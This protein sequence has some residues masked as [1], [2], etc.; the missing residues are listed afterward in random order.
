MHLSL[1]CHLRQRLCLVAGGNHLAETRVHQLLQ[2]GADI[3]VCASEL[4]P[5]LSALAE[6]QQIR[7]NQGR[8]H[9]GLLKGC[10]L[11]VATTS[12][13]TLNNQISRETNSAQIFCEI[14]QQQGS[15]AVLQ[16]T[17]TVLPPEMNIPSPGAGEV[18][19]VGAGP[20]DAGLLTLKALSCLQQADVVLA[21]RLV[22]DDIR[23]LICPAT[24]YISVGKQCG[25]HSTTQQQINQ[26]L[27]SQAQSGKRVV[28][29]KGGD[30]LIF[31]RGGEELEALAAT[32]I[33]FSV[34]PGITAASGCAAYAGI[35]LTHRDYA[36]SLR[37]IT[38]HTKHAASPPFLSGISPSQTT[39]FYMGL[40]QAGDI[41]QQL[42]AAGVS[43]QTP[44]AVIG[45]GTRREQKVSVG[46][47]HELQ[48]LCKDA[49]SPALII[50]GEVVRLQH[51]LNW[52]SAGQ[53]LI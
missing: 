14:S 1:V 22:S 29:L 41:Y 43:D 8:Y 12:D 25:R 36:D 50:V 27:I 34:V 28:R 4:T 20:G 49:A 16:T 11:V 32:G 38:G 37:L 33:R 42:T 10:W 23:A 6:Q 24:E 45:K 7:W 18:A 44:V 53:N 19:L 47:L 35:P 13:Q 46:I 26:L 5:G 40:Q 15:S 30:P 3:L 9:S 52:F 2:A 17:A 21:D 31:G 51:S 39:V 48:Q